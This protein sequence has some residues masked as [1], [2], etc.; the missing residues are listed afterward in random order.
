MS[1]YTKMLLSLL[2]ICLAVASCRQNTCNKYTD[3]YAP[4]NNLYTG[5]LDVG[6][7]DNI[8]GLGFLFYTKF[9]ATTP[10][11]IAAAPTL[12]WLNGGPG[13]SSMEGA[14][15][16]NGPYRVLNISNQMVV[17]QN[18]NAWTKNY[19]VLFIDQPIGVGFS[20]S[21][22]DEYLP[23]NETQVAEQFYK[24]LLNFYTSGCYSDSIYHKSPLFITGESYC[25]KYIPNIAT[26]ILKQNNQTDVTGNVKIPLK[27]ISIGDPLLDPQHQLYFLGQ[28]GIENNLISYSTYF[29]VNNILTRMKQHFDLNMYEEAADDYDEA[30]E[31]FMSKAF[32]ELENPY[33]YNIGPY[34]DQYV[35]HFC[36]TYIQ[37]FGFDKDHVYDST[38]A[39]I[40]NS[41]KHDV[42]VPNGIP[43]L[44]NVLE[45]NLPVIIYNGNYDI[46]VNTP[47]IS[48]AVNNF[49]WY[50]KQV[51]SALP[52]Q[53]LHMPDEQGN[54]EVIGSIKVYDKFIY[55]LINAAGHLAP[56]DQPER[57][58]YII[59]NF[60]NKTLNKHTTNQ[61]R[62][63][64]K[65]AVEY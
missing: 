52:M 16:E 57:V 27:G 35:K 53:D 32:T 18:E 26:E 47:G 61:F 7:N 45:Q 10:E 20:R 22:K 9:N 5:Y 46:Q 19:N 50:G 28:Y 41:L 65:F 58:G 29:Q 54:Q 56:Y 49:E 17:E 48:Y 4:N 44:V 64:N 60:V 24:G 31:T 40:S 6:F 59:D 43:A 36:Q 37:N 23:V 63:F 14:F 25:G 21:A 33:N 62:S 13:S 2:A 8:T 51:F 38:S 30:M 3:V 15:F 39:K 1:K 11:E 34:P 55:A 12:I 42:F